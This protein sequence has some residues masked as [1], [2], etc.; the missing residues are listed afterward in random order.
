MSFQRQPQP[1]VSSTNP[2]AVH[3]LVAQKG[4]LYFSEQGFFLGRDTLLTESIT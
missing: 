1:S 3:T 4:N 2:L